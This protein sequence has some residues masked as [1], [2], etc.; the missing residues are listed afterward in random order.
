MSTV[1]EG[2]IIATDSNFQPIEI[3]PITH[4]GR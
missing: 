1:N 2:D 3:I 4:H